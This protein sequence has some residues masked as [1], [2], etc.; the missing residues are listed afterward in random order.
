MSHTLV[1]T[2]N[3]GAYK[4]DKRHKDYVSILTFNTTAPGDVIPYPADTENV[5]IAMPATH[6]SNNPTLRLHS[7]Q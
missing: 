1:V 2:D 5:V 4:Q 3:S 7:L 6:T